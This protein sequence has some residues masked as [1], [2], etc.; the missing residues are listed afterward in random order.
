[1][2]DSLDPSLLYRSIDAIDVV[3]FA[4]MLLDMEPHGTAKL[5][6]ATYASAAI[7]RKRP[8]YI[9]AE[10]SSIYWGIS[11]ELASRTLNSATPQAVRDLPMPLVQ[12]GSSHKLI[13]WN[14]SG[15]ATRCTL[16]PCMPSEV[17]HAEH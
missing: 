9:T 6:G 13:V 7:V 17:L 4:G 3:R 2:T 16:I 14:A 8:G 15:E 5:I 1:M 12:E 10:Q 11:L